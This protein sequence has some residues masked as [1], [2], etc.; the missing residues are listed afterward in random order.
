MHRTM[1]LSTI[2]DIAKKEEQYFTQEEEENTVAPEVPA[3]EQP[4]RPVQRADF[5]A[6][7]YLRS[8][9]T[10]EQINSVKNYNPSANGNFVEFYNKTMTKPSA[11]DEKKAR[12]A[13]T[14]AGIADA[15]GSVTQ[16][17]GVGLGAHAKERTKFALSEVS[18]RQRRAQELYE[19]KRSQYERGLYD[20]Q[21][22]DYMDNQNWIRSLRSEMD[23]ARRYGEGQ[24]NARV[25]REDALDQRRAEQQFKVL[26]LGLKADLDERRFGETGRHNRAVESA[27]FLRANNQG[28]RNNVNLYGA[29]TPKGHEDFH[30]PNTGEV[31]RINKGEFRNNVN[32]LYNLI[33]PH[34]KDDPQY[35]KLIRGS[36]GG[37]VPEAMRLNI[38][39]QYMYDYPDAIRQLE[40][41]S[42]LH[43]SN[44]VSTKPAQQPQVPFGSP[45]PMPLENNRQQPNQ[46]GNKKIGW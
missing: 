23:N 11:P 2:D 29:T 40:L 34:I 35:R 1:K 26:Q 17:V 25:A 39:K 14:L 22:R 38:V 13:R 32:N 33:L 16:M 7:E 15:L 42:I 10:D 31:Y 9:Y 36:K 19:Q 12:R 41:L 28:N 4:E 45:M 20:A 30:D 3:T 43:D 24:H 18:D 6:D 37:V 44:S 21:G 46:G 8:R 5:N 27:A